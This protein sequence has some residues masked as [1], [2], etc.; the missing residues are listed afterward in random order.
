MKTFA[1]TTAAI[2]IVTIAT[3][4][5]VVGQDARSSPVGEQ[6]TQQAKSAESGN[7][8]PDVEPVID[9]EAR[10]L[11]IEL[12]KQLSGSNEEL[13][14]VAHEIG[15]PLIASFKH[16][17]NIARV[18]QRRRRME[19]ARVSVVQLAEEAA[20]ERRALLKQMHDELAKIR[21]QFADDEQIC[22][23]EQ[24]AVVQAFRVRL[25]AL[26]S[27]E[28]ECLAKAKDTS[29]EL[30]ALRRDKVTRERARWLAE[31]AP[32]LTP[33]T[34]SPVPRLVW[35]RDASN[36]VQPTAT[37]VLRKKPTESLKEALASLKEFSDTK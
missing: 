18:D 23:S 22:E 4:G 21:K 5:I 34:K 24:V 32:Q 25:H 15:L 31:K 6:P 27:R 3:S 12:R 16:D 35:V 13:S 30:I 14:K 1:N 10:K 28:A 2:V 17:L 37:A 9:E 29:T 8:K 11:A 26:K 33:G 20:E 7:A 19:T 36:R